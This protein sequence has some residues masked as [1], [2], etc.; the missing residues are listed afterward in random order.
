MRLFFIIA[1]TIY[2][3]PNI[4]VLLRLRSLFW[5]PLHKIIFAII[6][7]LLVL[8]FPISE[9][10]AHFQGGRLIRV[11]VFI[12]YYTLPWLLY[13]FL[14]LLLFELTLGAN[15]IFKFIETATLQSH[16]FRLVSLCALFILP[17]LA[18]AAGIINYHIIRVRKYQIEIPRRASTLSQLR[19]VFAADFHLRDITTRRFMQTFV[20]KVN[21]QNPDIVLIPGDI[22]EGDRHKSREDEFAAQFRRIKSKYGVFASLGNHEFYGAKAGSDFFVHSGIRVLEDEFVNVADAF[23]CAGRLDQHYPHRKPLDDL[24]RGIPKN[25]PL[26]MLDHRPKDMLETSRADVDIQVMGHTHNGQLFPLNYIVR[27][28]YPLNWGYRKINNTHFFVT[29]G[30]QTWGPPVKTS[31]NNEIVVIDVKLIEESYK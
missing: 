11:F 15:R 5:N 13:L 4:Y 17:A 30:I 18:M 20:E 25:L 9:P 26:I 29:S 14:F 31:S 10:L 12:A 7:A 3:A 28:V 6:Y 8:N 27:C 2:F 22:L 21:A 16:R 19:I 24:M 1:L 23:Y